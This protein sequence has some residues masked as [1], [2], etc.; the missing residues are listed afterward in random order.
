ML[1]AMPDLN[2]DDLA[3][4]VRV[5]DCGGFALAARA[6]GTPTSTVSRAIT[7][8]ESTAG[9]RLLHRTTRHVQPTGEGR[10]L[11]A[12]VSPAVATLLRA[13]RSV[14]PAAKKP[15]GRLRVSAPNDLCAT[16]LADVIVAF[17]A[18]YP[19]V[20]LDFSLTNAH[21]NL[22][23]EGFDIA[24][25]AT[26]RLGDSSLV[27]RK[28]GDLELRLYASPKY[29][30]EHGAPASWEDLERHR[31]IVFRAKELQRTWL[32]RS[33]KGEQSVDVHGCM[34]GDD[35]TFVR[36][37][38]MAGGGIGVLPHIN[39][40]ADE[41]S[42]RLVRVLPQFHQRGASLYIL[43]PSSRNVAARVTAFRD[44]VVDA[45]GAWVA[46]RS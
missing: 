35:F 36:A 13:A 2:L 38:V 39:S 40:V 10:D 18:Q 21:S 8:L 33:A 20:H 23:T 14:E 43:I 7:R 3:V 11:D 6:I 34:G 26:A 27:A 15:K 46:K 17:S 25:R 16:F 5:V 29:L 30:E 37:I 12:S 1:P 28:L 32:L 41:L 22:V 19:Q 45:Y 42:G 9:V 24:L 4:F 31:C 44:F